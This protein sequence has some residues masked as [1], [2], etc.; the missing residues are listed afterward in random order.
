MT[1]AERQAKCQVLRRRYF[2]DV[3][4]RE[5]MMDRAV[6]DALAP[7]KTLL[8]AGCGHDAP[9]L[10]RYL[11][12]VAFGVGIDVVSPS[13]KPDPRSAVLV[14]NLETLPFRS[15]SFD[16]VVSRS[17]VEHLSN[18]DGVFGEISRVLRPGGRVIFTTPNKYYY[19]SIVAGLVSYRL[20]DRFM[21]SVFG[22]SG[23]DH[24]PVFYRANTRRALRQVAARAG[25][26][27]ERVQALRHYP[28]YF[29]FSPTL[30]RLGIV[31]DRVVTKLRLD[32]LQSTWLVTMVKPASDR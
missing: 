4:S 13:Q 15:G 3:P 12:R 27:L 30:F 7:T 16:V 6:S 8:D 23:Y 22:D 9:I 26:R 5:E 19:S 2:A 29:L 25:L 28:F 32:D 18:P 10:R 1:L 31:Y 24:F 17:V 20:K 14:G 11:D 21:R